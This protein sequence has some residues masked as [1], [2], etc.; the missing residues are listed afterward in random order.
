MESSKTGTQWLI[1]AAASGACASL[2]G[3]FAKLTTTDLTTSWAS[4]VSHAL[5][6]GASNAVVEATVRAAFFALNLLFNAIMWALFT[7]ALTLATSTVRVS[8][9]NTSANFVLTAMLGWLVFAE[10]LPGLWWLGASLL[11]A[12]SVIIGGREEAQAKGRVGAG[13]GGEASEPLSETCGEWEEDVAD[14][15]EL[16][17]D[18]LDESEDVDEGGRG[19]DEFKGR[20]GE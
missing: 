5:G 10:R 15:G 4:A 12:G 11:V 16:F 14:L 13:G 8:I 9:I 3:V 2:N 20:M 18:E 1:F 6:F 19:S 7:R 17:K